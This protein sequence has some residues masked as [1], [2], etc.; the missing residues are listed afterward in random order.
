MN[1]TINLTAKNLCDRDDIRV[2]NGKVFDI[3]VYVYEWIILSTCH[4]SLKHAALFSTGP[5]LRYSNMYVSKY[6]IL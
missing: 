2:G 3:L 4:A 5:I 1:Q 6:V